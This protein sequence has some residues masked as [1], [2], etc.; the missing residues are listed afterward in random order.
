[1]DFVSVYCNT[2]TPVKTAKWPSLKI[3]RTEYFMPDDINWFF[4]AV[5]Q[6]TVGVETL[7]PKA[8]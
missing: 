6:K 5:H 4:Q 8:L 7:L 1:M 2:N 3:H